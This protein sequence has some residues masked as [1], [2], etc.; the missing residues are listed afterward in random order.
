MNREDIHR[1]VALALAESLN[2]EQEKIKPEA[3]LQADLGAE[4]IDLLEIIFR[5]EQEFGIKIRDEEFCPRSM[6]TVE[7]ITNYVGN[8][9]K[10]MGAQEA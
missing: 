8:K 10:R 2:V 4:S 5:L 3:N 7:T 9:L 6:I 1:K